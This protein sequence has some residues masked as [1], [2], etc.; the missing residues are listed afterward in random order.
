MQAIDQAEGGFWSDTY[1]GRPI[2]ILNHCGRWLVYLDHVLQ[3]RM[4]FVSAEAA[5][6]WLHSKVDQ[7]KGRGRLH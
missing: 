7:P 1:R 4:Q 5:V 6:N 2:A 3:T